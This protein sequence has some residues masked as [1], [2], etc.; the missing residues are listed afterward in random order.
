MMSRFC[1]QK[2]LFNKDETL[3][4]NLKSTMQKRLEILIT[5]KKNTSLDVSVEAGK[6]YYYLNLL[7]CPKHGI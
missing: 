6:N 5:T 4:F 3:F 1:G 7:N 2:L